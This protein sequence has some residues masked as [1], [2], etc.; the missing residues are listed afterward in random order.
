MMESISL[1]SNVYIVSSMQW[2]LYT[3]LEC[4]L[5]KLWSI[6]L[7]ASI[8]QIGRCTCRHYIDVTAIHISWHDDVIKWKHFPRYWPFV[9]GIN[10][11]IA[12]TKPVTRSFD[13][14][15]DLRLNN[16]LSKQSWGWWFETLSCPLWRQRNGNVNGHLFC[17]IAVISVGRTTS[18]GHHC[19][20][21]TL[22]MFLQP[23]APFA[24]MV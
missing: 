10:R 15:F 7:S 8:C 24:N 6:L 11:W 21:T 5:S 2:K 22:D 3:C 9:R 1:E 16:R 19:D 17:I 14:F 23:V 18:D 13:V 4:Y 20:Y 12:R